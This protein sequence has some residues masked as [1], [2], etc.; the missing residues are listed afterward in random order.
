MPLNLLIRW[1]LQRA[2]DKWQLRDNLWIHHVPPVARDI[3]Y[4]GHD[5]K[6]TSTICINHRDSKTRFKTFLDGFPAYIFCVAWDCHEPSKAIHLTCLN[7]M[8][9]STPW[10]H[11]V[12]KVPGPSAEHIHLLWWWN[13]RSRCLR[14]IKFEEGENGS[15]KKKMVK[16]RLKGI[17]TDSTGGTSSKCSSVEDTWGHGK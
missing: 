4:L 12:I 9:S 11:Q 8:D 6:L 1:V 16:D 10:Q 7:A 2:H 17:K 13:L 14:G 15:C 5:V 3:G